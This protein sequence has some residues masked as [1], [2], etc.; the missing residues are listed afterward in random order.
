MVDSISSTSL[1]LLRGI[2]SKTSNAGSG[3][4]VGPVQSTQGLAPETDQV[5]I[6]GG[7]KAASV[8]A[9]LAAK[10]PPFD[11]ET[12]T[13]IKKAIEDGN[14]PI[15]VQKITESLF[16]GHEDMLLG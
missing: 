11:L 13:R 16:E 6:G 3:P 9:E 1:G 5:E 2:A 14:Y 8:T 7:A 12:V 4:S 15:D 10:A